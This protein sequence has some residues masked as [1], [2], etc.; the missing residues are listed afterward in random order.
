MKR[1]DFLRAH[2]DFH[3][4]MLAFSDDGRELGEIQKLDKENLTIEKG[5]FFS[6]DR[7]LPYDAVADIRGDHV[8]INRGLTELEEW[9]TPDYTG[10]H[11]SRVA[12][13]K[14][15]RESIP[16]SQKGLEDLQRTDQNA[17][18]SAPMEDA[19]D[20]EEIP[21]EYTPAGRRT[22]P[23]PGGE[24]FRD[25]NEQ[26]EARKEVR[27]ESWEDAGKTPTEAIDLDRDRILKDKEKK[28]R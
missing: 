11:K 19:T 18:A 16:A 22:G 25:V 23:M 24:T 6:M 10:L 1:K 26:A 9:K 28:E 7:R 4:G 20:I 2:P 12:D 3:P 15:A 14:Q 27:S 21:A 5:E 8:I 17:E 13:V